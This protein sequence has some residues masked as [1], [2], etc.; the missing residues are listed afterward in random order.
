MFSSA[1]LHRRGRPGRISADCRSHYCTFVAI[2][3]VFSVW[4]HSLGH[5]YWFVLSKSKATLKADENSCN[6]FSSVFSLER[7]ITYLSTIVKLWWYGR[8]KK[9]YFILRRFPFLSVMCSIAVQNFYLS[10]GYLPLTTLFV[11]TRTSL[12]VQKFT[13][14]AICLF[15]SHFLLAGGYVHPAVPAFLAWLGL[16]L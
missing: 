15:S 1:R 4:S 7:M 9:F 6:Y 12:F 5:R 13:F 16:V 2:V 14:R 8:Y 3:D 10:W 11:V